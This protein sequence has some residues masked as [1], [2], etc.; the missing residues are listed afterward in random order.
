MKNKKVLIVEDE[1]KIVD[2]LIDYL[3]M[4]GFHIS[5][6]NSGDGVISEVKKNPPDL[7]ILDIILPGKDGI[8]ICSEIRSFSNVPIL[9]CTGRIDEIDRILGLEIGADDYIC[10]PFSPREVVARAKALTRRNGS[11]EYEATLVI[12]PIIIKPESHIATIFGKKLNLTPNEFELLKIMASR[13]GKVFTRSDLIS[14]LKGVN[15]GG[16]K[17]IIDSHMKNLRKK[18]DNISPQADIIRTVHKFGY[19]LDV[20]DG[21]VEQK[22]H[23]MNI[24]ENNY[25]WLE[26]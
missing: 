6:L 3:G 20:S 2:L 7:I 14:N 9:I 1:Q 22:E 8:T 4:A 13:P 23:K 5:V 12:G 10:K 16:D 15:P 26:N 18:I 17:R 24:M 25:R 19:S 21:I 11:N